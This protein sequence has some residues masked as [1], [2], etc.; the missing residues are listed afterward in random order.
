MAKK[1]E[2]FSYDEAVK[3]IQDIVA[4]LENREQTTGFDEMIADVEKA[5]SLIEKCKATVSD[6]EAKLNKLTQA[7]SE[8]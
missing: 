7:V 5:L 6:A 4:K 8:A 3:N 1:E 2:K